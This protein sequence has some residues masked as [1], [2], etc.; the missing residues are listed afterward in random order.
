MYIRIL[1]VPLLLSGFI[2]LSCNNSPGEKQQ[3]ENPD[4]SEVTGFINLYADMETPAVRDTGDAADDPCVWIHPEDPGRSLILG[5]NKQR[6]LAVYDLSGEELFFSPMGRVNNVDVRYNFPLGNKKIDIVAASNRSDNS[7]ALLQI[8]ESGTLKDIS[9]TVYVSSVDGV[10]GICLYHNKA[11]N[12]YYVIVNSKAGQVEQWLLKPGDNMKIQAEL[13]RSF[14][15]GGLTEGCVAD[16]ELGV[17]YIG[18]EDHGIWRYH[19]E[20]D[21]G[22]ER[23]A[24]DDFNNPKLA[25]DIEGLTIY[26][27]ANGSGY[28]IASSQGNNSYA[29]YSRTEPNEYLGSFRIIDEKGGIDGTEDTDG[30]DVINLSMDEQYPHGF[31]IAQDGYNYEKGQKTTQN[32]KMISWKKIAEAFTPPLLIDNSY[33]IRD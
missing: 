11:K 26:Y 17:L 20:P 1:I 12:T 25:A 19:A 4:K 22:N 30:I 7:I 10:Y 6:G 13:V 23:T 24:V 28:L 33:N 27:G 31:F 2:L 18:Q 21:M 29:V 5:T 32:F 16:D 8:D 3:K 9:D 14:E 15:V